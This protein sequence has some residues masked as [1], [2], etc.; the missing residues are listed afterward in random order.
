MILA[1]VS[2]I[3]SHGS[4]LA[5][6]MVNT[7]LPTINPSVSASCRGQA[8]LGSANARATELANFIANLIIAIAIPVAVIGIISTAYKLI[9]SQGNPDAMKVAKKN[10]I[11]LFIGFFIIAFAALG[12]RA[13]VQALLGATTP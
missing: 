2:T 9:T 12:V 1:A 3:Y 11:S 5:F 4:V 6:R 10:L 13:V 8:C 7:I